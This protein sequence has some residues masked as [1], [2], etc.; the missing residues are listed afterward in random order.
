[1]ICKITEQEC[2][3]E[4]RGTREE[5]LAVIRACEISKY[6]SRFNSTEKMALLRVA[7]LFPINECE[8]VENPESRGKRWIDR[9]TEK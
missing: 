7:A 4:M 6:D 3:L 1:M 8:P 5:I 9:M 2:N